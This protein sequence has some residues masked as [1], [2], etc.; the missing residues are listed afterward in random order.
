MNNREER[1]PEVGRYNAGQKL[2]FFVLVVCMI[3]LLLS[4]IVIWRA[5]FSLYFPVGVI[6]LASLVHAAVRVRAD[7]RH[8][9]AHLCGD[10]GEGLDARHDARH[11]DAGLGLETSSGLVPRDKGPCNEFSIPARL[12]RLRSERSR[13][14]RLPDRAHVF[15]RCAPSVCVNSAATTRSDTRLGTICA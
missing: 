2:L 7:L 14:L 6:R 1:L 10:L 4:G 11:R 15:L 13:R 3:G 8:H 5:Y 12:R 9:P